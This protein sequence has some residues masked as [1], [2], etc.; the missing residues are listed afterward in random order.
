MTRYV[1]HQDRII[2]AA[3]QR[4]AQEDLDAVDPLQLEAWL[5]GVLL[6]LEAIGAQL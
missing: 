5:G 1:S 3:V 6:A 4:L 2:S